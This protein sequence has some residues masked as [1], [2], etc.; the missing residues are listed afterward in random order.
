MSQSYDLVIRG[1]MVVDGTGQRAPFQADI[2]IAGGTIRT[3]GAIGAHGGEE[4]DATG[5]LVTPG[6]VDIHTHYDAQ[7]AWESRLTPS[8]DHGTT[9]ALMGNCGIGFAPCAAE[10][11]DTL[12][13]LMEGVEDIPGVVMAECLSW[14]WESYPDYLNVIAQ[15]EFDMDV[16]SLLPHAPLRI[17]VMGQ[18]AADLEPATADDRQRMHDL[19]REAAEAGALGFGTS[20]TIF[21][22]S[23]DGSAIPTLTAGEDEIMAIAAGMASVGPRLMQ[24]ASDAA[25]EPAAATLLEEFAFMRRIGAASGCPVTYN[26]FPVDQAPDNWRILLDLNAAANRD[27]VV[28]R[29]QTMIKSNGMILGLEVRLNPF[30]RCPSYMALADRPLDERVAALRDAA[31]K[32]RILAEAPVTGGV[33]IGDFIRNDLDKMFPLL[34]PPDYEPRPETSLAAEARRQGRD[35]AEFIYDY[36]LGED[37]RALIYWPFNT[38]ADHSLDVYAEVLKDEHVMVGIAD[39]GAHIG[40]IC[41]VSAMTFMLSYW[42]RDRVGADRMAIEKVVHMLTEQPAQLIGLNDRGRIAVG[43]RADLNVIDFERLALERPMAVYDL[44]VAGINRLVQKTR[45]YTA[46]IVAGQVTYR[47]GV[48]TGALPGRLVR[49]PQGQAG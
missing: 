1:G 33:A 9:T 25:L 37:G 4:I 46:T 44:P 18:R 16:A 15:R 12:V 2:G 43:L 32:V 3:V 7:V 14:S 30:F 20:R 29:P 11:R 26:V 42:A 22:R 35:P 36:L 34:D 41:D 31:L 17:H 24:F 47:D 38:Y 5:K 19:A 45:G 39:G 27:G 6:F 49:G 13:R 10:N 23:T 21:H 8:S 48:P 40:I 28:M